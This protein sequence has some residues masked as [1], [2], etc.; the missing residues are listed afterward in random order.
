MN[1]VREL[2]FDSIE[3]TEVPV[4]IAG[5]K[6]ILREA[7]T[8]TAVAYKDRMLACTSMTDGGDSVK[9]SG[10]AQLEPFLVKKCLFYG[11]GQE[12][13]G[14]QV[15]PSF[16]D[17]LPHKITKALYNEVREI[18]DLEESDDDTIEK[19]EKKLAKLK[20]KRDAAGNGQSGTTD[21][22]ESPTN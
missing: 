20:R 6:Y 9:I 3:L 5:L 13:E 16:V 12:H 4:T 15:V 7:D 22:S 14:K 2:N 18:S 21:S 1:A 19:L 11:P 17:S 8:P 10:L